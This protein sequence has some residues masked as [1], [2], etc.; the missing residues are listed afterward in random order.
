MAANP[1]VQTTHEA[2]ARTGEKADG[3]KIAGYRTFQ[4][5]EFTFARDEYF[6]IVTWPAKN[7]RQSHTMSADAFLRAMM[8]DVAWNFFYGLVNFDAVFGTRN[9]YGRVE[10]FAGRYNEAIHG[11]GLSYV[12]AFDSAAAMAKFKEILAD[13]VNAGF[14]PFAAP[15]EVEG[16]PFGEKNGNNLAAID[17]FRVATKR[18]T[19][20]E[21]DSPLRTDANGFP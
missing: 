20:I 14:D 16:S 19:G 17:R 5:G 15:A 18:M 2:S 12:E 21:G 8:R 3:E 1:Q 6:V 9:L 11:A 4:L 10:L 13:W 7:K